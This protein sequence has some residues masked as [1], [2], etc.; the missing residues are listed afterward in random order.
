MTA[1]VLYLVAFVFLCF[2]FVAAVIAFGIVLNRF[3]RRR[4][5]PDVVRARIDDLAALP[6]PD[7]L[8]R[9]PDVTKGMRRRFTRRQHPIAHKRSGRPF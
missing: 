9:A 8:P 7:E 1:A 2:V 4:R 5:G 3:L 6:S